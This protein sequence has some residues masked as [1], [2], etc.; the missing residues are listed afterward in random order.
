MAALREL[1]GAEPFIF[2]QGVRFEHDAIDLTKAP[3]YSGVMQ[4]CSF[5][6]Y[7]VRGNGW[8]MGVGAKP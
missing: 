3:P 8:S 6:E 4:G 1:Y 7:G 5:W 2:A